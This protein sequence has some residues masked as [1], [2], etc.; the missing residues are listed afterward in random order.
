MGQTSHTKTN[1]LINNNNNNNMVEYAKI[2]QDDLP[3]IPKQQSQLP[4]A[5]PLYKVVEE[6][7]IDIVVPKSEESS[8]FSK[9]ISE[10]LPLDSSR[11]GS[12]GSAVLG[13]PLEIKQ[14]WGVNVEYL[15]FNEAK[16][17]LARNWRAGLSPWF[18]ARKWKSE[19]KV[20]NLQKKTMET[21]STLK[22]KASELGSGLSNAASSFGKKVSDTI[23]YY[24]LESHI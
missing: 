14:D 11:M 17:K 3:M 22:E 15:S 9:P 10:E 23:E 5:Q 20:D 16:E 4:P 19:E 18:S 24:R 13:K 2:V 12:L 21:A 8:F 7:E 6:I 1:Q